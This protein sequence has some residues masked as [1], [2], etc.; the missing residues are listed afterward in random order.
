MTKGDTP[1]DD[2]EEACLD[3]VE[4]VS[5]SESEEDVSEEGST[6]VLLATFAVMTETTDKGRGV[7]FPRLRNK[8][9]LGVEPPLKS[10]LRKPLAPV[11]DWKTRKLEWERLSSLLR[12]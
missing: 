3:A 6:K 10:A 11:V 12:R 1:V 7:S 4:S 9:R 8:P 2:D 5:E